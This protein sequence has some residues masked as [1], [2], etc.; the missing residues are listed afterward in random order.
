[1]KC[2]V[3]VRAFQP[4]LQQA[5]CIPYCFYN[6]VIFIGGSRCQQTAEQGKGGQAYHG[7]FL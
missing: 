1:M 2:G 6:I 5:T 4:V 7:A 3:I